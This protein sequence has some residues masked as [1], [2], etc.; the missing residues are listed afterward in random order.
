LES[1]NSPTPRA[2]VPSGEHPEP[3]ECI[4]LFVQKFTGQVFVE[5]RHVAAEVD[6][7]AAKDTPP[8]KKGRPS[9][10]RPKTTEKAKTVALN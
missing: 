1:G 4:K 2:A 10:G 6:G 5:K 9:T 8:W 7:T 3:R